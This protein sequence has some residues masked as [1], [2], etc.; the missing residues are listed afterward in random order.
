MTPQDLTP[1]A[2]LARHIAEHPDSPAFIEGECVTSF[3]AFGQH[4]GRTAAWLARQG[5]GP[6]DRVGVW[7]VNRVEWLALFFALGRLGATLVAVNT[8]YR[9]A[10]L[11]HIL[12][13]SG[14]RLLVLQLNFRS[15]DFPAVLAGVDSAKLPALE[16]IAVVDAAGA[17]L[18]TILGKPAVAFD[19][20][21]T[22]AVPPADASAADAPLILF[23]T[24][25]TTRGPKLVVHPQRTLTL[26]GQ[27]CAAAF[28]LG[29]PDAK[30]LAAMPFCG[31]FGMAALMAAFAGGI[32]SV[33]LDAVDAEATADLIRRHAVTHTFGS[34]EMFRRIGEIVPGHDPFPSARVFGFAAFGPGAADLATAAWARRIPMLGLYGSSEVLALFSMQPLHLP[35]AE[36][37]EGGGRPA[38]PDAEVRVRDID[39]GELLA[40]GESGEIEIR[41][42]TNFSGYLNNPEATA[43]AVRPDGFFRTGDLG[44]LR[45]D[46]TFVYEARRGDAIRLGGFLVSPT[47]I[48]DVLKQ[49]PGVADVQVVAV[50]IAG[51][52]RAVAFAIASPAREPAEA[53]V[54]A[55]AKAAMAAFKVPARVWFIDEF[56]TT[57]SA[58][59]TKIQKAKLREMAMERLRAET[60]A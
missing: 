29:A 31:V 40:P 32:P 56:P 46:G 18:Q 42:P 1:T 24:S 33:L 27:R 35:I 12:G 38:S 17:G 11:E 48:E 59:G 9:S 45:S 13:L 43:E 50:E 19:A 51:Q 49:V 8:R 30:L 15:I 4:V 23:T 28:G 21:A 54:I 20:F 57:P 55:A 25:G 34:D 26:H 5:I 53:E 10:E 47:E 7:L 37:V 6:G 44:R 39:S 60:G 14:A 16:R 36:R 58:N 52:M 22:E 2:L 41:A 3:A